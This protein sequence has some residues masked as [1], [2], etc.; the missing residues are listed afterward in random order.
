M[1]FVK[2]KWKYTIVTLLARLPN[3]QHRGLDFKFT[4]LG[5]DFRYVDHFRVVHVILLMLEHCELHDHESM[6]Q[7]SCT[8]PVIAEV[9]HQYTCVK[10]I[11]KQ[12]NTPE[13]SSFASCWSV[14]YIKHRCMFRT[15]RLCTKKLWGCLNMR[16][17]RFMVIRGFF[18]WVMKF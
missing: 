7:A 12:K 2:P 11:K 6:V 4:G 3:V 17:V 16:F 14:Y 10:F 18:I 15:F 5:L 8:Q 13:S 1:G 9:L